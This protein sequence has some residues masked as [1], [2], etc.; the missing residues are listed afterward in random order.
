MDVDEDMNE[1]ILFGS[2]SDTQQKQEQTPHMGST[3]TAQFNDQQ[4]SIMS[5]EVSGAKPN[6][7]TVSIDGDPF[8][9]E[10]GAKTYWEQNNCNNE[11][12]NEKD[13]RKKGGEKERERERQRERERERQRG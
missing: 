8:E 9:I 4:A 12:L 3:C 10:F 6:T 1:N 13:L 2:G 11:Q 5:E 7:R